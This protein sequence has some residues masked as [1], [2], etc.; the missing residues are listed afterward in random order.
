MNTDTS[1]WLDS[2]LNAA[3]GALVRVAIALVLLFVSF[4]LIGLLT[5]KIGNMPRIKNA[6]KTISKIML[7]ALSLSLRAL[8]ILALV[9][10][11]GIDTGGITTVI[12]SLGVGIGLA[13]NGTLSNFAG[14]FIIIVTRPFRIDDFIEAQGYSGTV[15]DIR[16]ICTKLR[17]PDN[18]VVYIPNGALSSGGIVNYSEKELRRLDLSFPITNDTDAAL[19]KSLVGRAVLECGLVLDEPL[20]TVRVRSFGADGVELFLRAWL[21]CDDYWTAYYD[22]IEAVRESF[23]KNGLCAPDKHISVRFVGEGNDKDGYKGKN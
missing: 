5:R 8:V 7:Y 3:L 19:A 17:T 9:S 21:R 15:E 1:A 18:K 13:V 22:I 23:V 10:F 20:A 2:F 16:V 6:D 11:V 14:G 4:R 12:A